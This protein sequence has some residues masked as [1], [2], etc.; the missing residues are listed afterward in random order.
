M[1]VT[2]IIEKRRE[3]LAE[4]VVNAPSDDIKNCLR[5]YNVEWRTVDNERSIN[6][7]SRPIIISTMEYLQV[8]D[9]DYNKEPLIK[10]M[11]CRIQNLFPDVCGFCNETYVVKVNDSPL[12]PC[13][14]CGQ[15][16][17]KP[18][19][20]SR[21]RLN[22][23]DE[24]SESDAR[25]I[26]NPLNLSGL[27]YICSHCEPTIIPNKEDGRPKRDGR[28]KTE[29]NKSRVPLT[30]DTRVEESVVILPQETDPVHSAT[31]DPASGDQQE[32]PGDRNGTPLSQPNDNDSDKKKITCRYYIKG[33]CK[34]GAKGSKCLYAHPKPCRK[35]INHG[36]RTKNGCNKGKK[37]TEF[38]PK[39]CQSSLT[40]GECFNSSCNLKHV[41]GTKFKKDDESKN[42][43]TP[44]DKNVKNGNTQGK[45]SSSSADK[46]D[47]LEVV[48]LLKE[49]LLEE[50]DI[51]IASAL[52]VQPAMNHQLNQWNQ[53]FNPMM[54][55]HPMAFPQKQM[56]LPQTLPTHLHHL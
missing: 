41:K 39:M 3:V 11:V 53:P 48:R 14:I 52:S 24:I 5:N 37:C 17:H 6:K 50:M 30:I 25:H 19:L 47:F 31:E 20:M 15:D 29:G 1:E 33:N 27:H 32:V 9:N 16:V 26:F 10:N 55:Q 34:H 38:H 43:S 4:L 23:A 42:P 13:K 7:S 44:P 56:N 18:C 45:Q 51:K 36:T 8:F 49:Q 54:F 21:L 46:T 28:S 40:K 12:L 2:E 22:N 35:L